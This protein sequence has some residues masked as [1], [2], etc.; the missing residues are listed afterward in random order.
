MPHPAHQRAQDGGECGAGDG[1]PRHGGRYEGQDGEGDAQEQEHR[2]IDEACHLV[3]DGL[4]EHRVLHRMQSRQAVSVGDPPFH[5]QAR[6]APV[7][8]IVAEQRA[9]ALGQ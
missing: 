1:Q 4:A 6:A 5:R 8:E 9:N 2:R 3:R 7:A